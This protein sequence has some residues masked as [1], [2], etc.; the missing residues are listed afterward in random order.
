[1]TKI[2]SGAASIIQCCTIE[3][4]YKVLQQ[5]EE[6]NYREEYFNEWH[7]I[8]SLLTVESSIFSYEGFGN[9][10]FLCHF[11]EEHIKK[12]DHEVTEIKCNIHSDSDPNIHYIF[13]D[14]LD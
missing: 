3:E 9:I 13:M 4:I 12:L 14:G 1:M 11:L 7:T 6:D 8:G 10:I 2:R 5:Q